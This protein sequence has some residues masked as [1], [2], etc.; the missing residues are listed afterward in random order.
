MNGKF[1]MEGKLHPG[2]KLAIARTVLANERTLL[3][4]LRTALGCLLGGAGLF[5]FFGH[6]VYEIVG[7]FLMI[8]SAVILCVGIRKYRTIKKLIGAIDPEDW[9]ALEAMVEK[10][11]KSKG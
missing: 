2:N 7:I 6:P 3:A 1:P 9:Q 8:I 4:I 5:K 11:R 10:D